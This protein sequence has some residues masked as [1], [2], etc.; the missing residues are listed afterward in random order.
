MTRDERDD[1]CTYEHRVGA[2]AVRCADSGHWTLDKKARTWRAARP[3]D[4]ARRCWAHGPG[5]VQPA[6]GRNRRGNLRPNARTQ[7]AALHLLAVGQE[8]TNALIA[9]DDELSMLGFPS[10][11]SGT[12]GSAVDP[13]GGDATR[14]AELTAWREELRDAIAGASDAVSHLTRIVARQRKLPPALVT[15]RDQT[16]IHTAGTQ[17]LPLC[18]D[19]LHDRDGSIDW[20]DP[21]CTEIPARRGLCARC[22][23]RE[24][25][26]RR[27]NGLAELFERIA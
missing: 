22:A 19:A 14:I 12:G 2:N 3:A 13:V 20:G 21:T 25:V 15:W 1:S 18:C 17:G 24:R 9:T 6:P 26:W 23:E 4:K 11:S 7:R 5:T 16:G 10:T 8:I 27:D